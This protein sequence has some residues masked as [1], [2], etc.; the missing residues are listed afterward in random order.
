MI[1]ADLCKDR[2][3]WVIASLSPRRYDMQPPNPD[4]SNIKMVETPFHAAPLTP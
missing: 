4:S 3:E 2:P 1:A